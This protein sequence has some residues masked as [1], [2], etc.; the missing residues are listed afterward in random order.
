MSTGDATHET[1]PSP[2][3]LTRIL[4]LSHKMNDRSKFPEK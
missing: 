3:S 1:V 4:K 2:L